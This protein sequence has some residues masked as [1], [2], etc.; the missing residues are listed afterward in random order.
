MN[1]VSESQKWMIEPKLLIPLQS[2]DF[3]MLISD[4]AESY[5]SWKVIVFTLWAI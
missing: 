5:A 1:G 2:N 4:K 3:F